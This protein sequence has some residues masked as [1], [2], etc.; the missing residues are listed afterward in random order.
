VL[1]LGLDHQHLG[2]LV[3]KE[4]LVLW[5][6]LDLLVVPVL[7]V[8]LG[9]QGLL[10][11]VPAHQHLDLLVA[12]VVLVILVVLVWGLLDL[13]VVPVL[14]VRL[15][16]QGLLVLV[17]QHLGLVV[18]V[19]ILVVLVLVLVHQHLG[20]LV[21]KELLVL[22]G[23]LD[24]LVVKVHQWLVKSHIMLQIQRIGPELL[25]I[26]CNQQLIGWQPKYMHLRV[27]Q[28]HNK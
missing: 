14:L 22:W 25:L 4:L 7:L 16:Q 12:V 2:I 6:L 11:L 17:H 10:V 20:I 24:L 28:Y 19:D 3:V 21:V 18:L 27:N 23:T 5:G 26:T 1:V 8:R 15:G 13:L 9:Q